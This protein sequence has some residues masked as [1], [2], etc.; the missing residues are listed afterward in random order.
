[1]KHRRRL[2]D[3]A[4]SPPFRRDSCGMVDVS[5]VASPTPPFR[6]GAVLSDLYDMSTYYGRLQYN[7]RRMNPLQL[8]WSAVEIAQANATLAAYDRGDRS[9]SDAELW[10]AAEIREVTCAPGSDGAMMDG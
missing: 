5:V 1:M 9:R 7:W 8:R 6:A 2:V 3:A 4:T 10:R